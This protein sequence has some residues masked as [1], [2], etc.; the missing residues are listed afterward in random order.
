MKLY[1]IRTEEGRYKTQTPFDSYFRYNAELFIDYQLA[2]YCCPNDE[3]KVV[4][5]YLRLLRY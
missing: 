1:M 5:C 2:Q 3:Y 4:E